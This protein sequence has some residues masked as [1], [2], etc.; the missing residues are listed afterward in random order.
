MAGINDALQFI[1]GYRLLSVHPC[2]LGV[3]VRFQH[4][5]V[6]TG[7]DGGTAHAED[8]VVATGGMAG[9]GDYG[10]KSLFLNSRDGG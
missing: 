5:T 8:E 1:R 3:V 9:V 4:Q 6:G 7:S 2:L 10:Q